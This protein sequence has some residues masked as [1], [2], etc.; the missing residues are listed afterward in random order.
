MTGTEEIAR[1]RALCTDADPPWDHYGR[2][3]KREVA[4]AAADALNKSP[5]RRLYQFRARQDGAVWLLERRMR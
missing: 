1:L 2:H 5:F 4:E 3:P